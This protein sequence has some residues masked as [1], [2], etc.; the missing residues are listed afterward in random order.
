MEFKA[1]DIVRYAYGKTGLARLRTPHA[2]GWHADQCLGGIVFVS[3]TYPNHMSLA[4]E[5]DIA[6]AKQSKFYVL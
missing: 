4:T 1:G 6:E 3:D 2:N 5:E